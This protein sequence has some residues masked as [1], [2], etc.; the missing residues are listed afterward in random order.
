MSYSN[1]TDERVHNAPQSDSSTPTSLSVDLNMAFAE[2]NTLLREAQSIL[3]ACTDRLAECT[4]VH[5][6]VKELASS[7]CKSNQTYSKACAASATVASQAVIDVHAMMIAPHTHIPQ[8]VIPKQTSQVLV[9]PKQTSE[10]STIA[11]IIP[12]SNTQDLLVTTQLDAKTS[13]LTSDVPTTDEHIL[14]KDVQSNASTRRTTHAGPAI[15]R[16]RVAFAARTDGSN[17]SPRRRNSSAQRYNGGTGDDDDPHNNPSNDGNRDDDDSH[18]DPRNYGNTGDDGPH[19]KEPPPLVLKLR[20]T[21]LKPS[22]V[23][24]TLHS[25][26]AAAM[27]ILT[28]VEQT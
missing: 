21:Q 22:E 26:T 28:L 19:D 5:T 3:D 6:T 15:D 13:A 4:E 9:I 23:S 2:G 8:N 16:S 1:V 11:S 12:A 17:P 14:S 7:I 24:L 27:M 10:V 18:D 25:E 20:E